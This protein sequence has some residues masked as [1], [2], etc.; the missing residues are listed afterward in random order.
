MQNAEGSETRDGDTVSTHQAGLDSLEA[1][2]ERPRRLRSGQVCI[3]GDFTDEVFPVHEAPM[4]PETYQ[5]RGPVS[6]R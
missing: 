1:R 6:I 5:D 4:N 3:R 2:I